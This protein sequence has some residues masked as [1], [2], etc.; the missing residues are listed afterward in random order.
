MKKFFVSAGL[1]ALG[2][3]G[4]QTAIADGVDV[5]APRNWSVSGTLRGF[6][7]DNYNITG[8]A[9]GSFGIEASP[10]VSFHLPLQQTDI[11]LR[12]TYGAYYYQDRDAAGLNP[13]DQTH[14]VDFWLDHAFTERWRVKVTDTFASGQ[15]PELIGPVSPSA[16]TGVNY[17]VNGDNIANHGSIALST[18]W[19]RLFSTE[20]TYNNGFY[21][22]DNSGAAL[23]PGTTLTPSAAGALGSPGWS[24]GWQQLNGAGSGG[25][26][27]A[28]L[29]NR[30]E[31]S[32]SLDLKWALQ[33][34][35]TVFIGYQLSWVNYTGNE[36]ISVVNSADPISRTPLLFANPPT[37]Q[38][39]FVYHSSDRDSLTHYGYVGIEHQFT[40][41][42]SG[43]L[44]GGASFTDS[45]ND[46][47]FPTTSWAPYVDLSLQYT[48]LPGSY[49]QIGFTHDIN[50]TDQVAPNTA[51]Q[52][53]QYAE[54]SV[55]Y[56]DI[57]HKI[58]S[59]LTATVIGRMQ[60]STYQGGAA[61]SDDETDYSLGV[62][63]TY[64][65][66][67]HFSADAGYNYDNVVTSIAGYS[68]SR[69]RVYLGLTANY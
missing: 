15:E 6:Y 10:S 36:P 20:L 30:V 21:D 1:V 64:Q 50:S 16:P 45:Y 38:R 53:T 26:S 7:D 59:K 67:Q 68:Y 25:A 14:Q 12:Y 44:R 57:N 46:P 42:L 60:Y 4:L 23:S 41:N 17:R 62:N 65:F 48:Y 13:F 56:A 35:T 2:A 29:L 8:N 39:S 11:G 54:S 3:A 37:G 43:T 47:L 19:T 28:G 51:G 5:A 9:K 66:T 18:D 22:Y 61:S 49:V 69:N 58:T 31:Q 52:L 32:V 40:A 63:L 33:P 24:P 55:L 27:L 34:E